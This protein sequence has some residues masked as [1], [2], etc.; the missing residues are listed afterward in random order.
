MSVQT[1]FHYGVDRAAGLCL[2]ATC[3]A[4]AAGYGRLPDP[5]RRLIKRAVRS[6]ENAQDALYEARTTPWAQPPTP[7]HRQLDL[8]DLR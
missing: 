1:D 2:D 4:R 3:S 8:L 5:H 6:L 7:K